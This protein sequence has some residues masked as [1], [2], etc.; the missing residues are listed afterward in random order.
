MRLLTFQ[1]VESDGTVYVQI[2]FR[3]NPTDETRAASNVPRNMNFHRMKNNN[4]DNNNIYASIDH[5]LKPKKPPSKTKHNMNCWHEIL[6]PTNQH[7]QSVNTTTNTH[8]HNILAQ[9]L[10]NAIQ[11]KQEWIVTHSR[12]DTSSWEI[13][14]F[15]NFFF[16]IRGMSLPLHQMMSQSI[17]KSFLIVFDIFVE[18]LV[19]VLNIVSPNEADVDNFTYLFRNNSG[20]LCQVW[21]ELET[22]PTSKVPSMTGLHSWCKLCQRTLVVYYAVEL[23]VFRLVTE[24]RRSCAVGLDPNMLVQLVR[25]DCIL[26][27]E[28]NEVCVVDRQK[29]QNTLNNVW[30]VP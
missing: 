9:E 30:R 13:K 25:S 19:S 24:S 16:K 5:T 14:K 3:K 2:N 10:Y 7:Q 6:V 1:N 28:A 21:S 29:V 20:I 18:S 26:L 4:N 15:G 23:Y 8:V 22:G 12:A 17:L 11:I 27:S